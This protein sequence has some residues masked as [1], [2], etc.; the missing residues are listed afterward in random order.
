MVWNRAQLYSAARETPDK[1][2]RGMSPPKAFK[3]TCSHPTQPLNT[4]P[5]HFP[6]E[7]IEFQSL[8]A[9]SMWQGNT[10]HS[11]EKCHTVKVTYNKPQLT[12]T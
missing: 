8:A 6:Q 4:S 9:R 3:S 1:R 7:T 11:S 5:R 10:R 12:D 2:G